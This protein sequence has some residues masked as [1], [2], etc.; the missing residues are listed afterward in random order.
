MIRPDACAHQRSAA[1]V[2]AHIGLAGDSGPAGR[3]GRSRANPATRD[4]GDAGDARGAGNAGDA[5]AASV[6]V[7][8]LASVLAL[9]ACVLVALAVAGAS[10]HR[11]AVAADLG[12]LAAAGR[13]LQGPAAACALADQVVRA[14]GGQLTGC[15]MDGEISEIEVSVRPGGTVGML[16][17]ARGSAR[18][19]PAGALRPPG[20]S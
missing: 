3:L 1:H 17:A 8:A 15:R 12:A 6:L 9:I 13:A 5:G 16:G 7:L 19:G 18:A 10:R 4:A 14:Q 20:R 2:A 11:A